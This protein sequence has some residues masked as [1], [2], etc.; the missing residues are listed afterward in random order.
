MHTKNICFKRANS[1]QSP[2]LIPTYRYETFRVLGNHGSDHLPCSVLLNRQN[3]TRATRPRAAFK[4][5]HVQPSQATVVDKLRCK[6]HKKGKKSA[7]QQPPWWTEDLDEAWRIK[8]KVAKCWQNL[9][10]SN[11]NTEEIDRAAEIMKTSLQNF[12]ELAKK[13]K[14]EKWESFCHEVNGDKALTKFWKLHRCK[15]RKHHTTLNKVIKLDTGERLVTDEE[16]GHVF[17]DRYLEQTDQKNLEDRMQLK[18]EIQEA[19]TE[20]LRY[21]DIPSFTTCSIRCILK[22]SSSTAPGP[23]GVSYNKI[24]SLSDQELQELADMYTN[25][26]VTGNIPEDWL[27]SYLAVI[28]KPGRDHSQ[29]NGYRI[30]TMQN[31]VGKLMEKQVA[32]QLTQD[33]EQKEALPEGLGSYRKGMDTWANAAVFAYDTYEGFQRKEETIAV[34]ID[35]EDAYNR[36]S[37]EVLIRM[38]GSCDINPIVVNWIAAA[39][40]R[41]T[42]ALRH[43]NW[44]SDPA[45]ITPGLPQ[46][47]PLSPVLYNVYTARLAMM[48]NP[49]GRILTFADDVLIYVKGR[50]R[51][52][53]SNNTQEVLS[54]VNGWCVDTGA[55]INP[56]KGTTLWC[57]LDNHIVKKVLPH[58]NM[59]G[60]TIERVAVMKYLG[61][62]F[63]RT[64]SFKDQVDNSV[65]KCTRG[66]TAVKVMAAAGIRQC[67]LFILFKAL[68]LSVIDYGLGLT[69]FS[70]AQIE[71]LER[72]QN[73][74]M[75]IVLGCPRNTSVTAMRY[76]LDLP[77][78]AERHKISQV[79]AM[80]TV[81]RNTTHLLH[82]ELGTAKGSRIKR[83]RS[84]LAEAED[85][86]TTVCDVKYIRKGEEWKKCDDKDKKYTKV[87]I[88]MGREKREQ[89]PTIVNSEIL[90]LIEQHTKKDD[91][92]IYTDGSVTRGERCGWGFTAKKDGKTIKEGSQ[93]YHCTTSS[94]KMEEEAASAALEWLSDTFH[95]GAAIVTDSQS[96]LKKIEQNMLKPEWKKCIEQ[97][98]LQSL[99]WIFTPGHAGVAGNE[100]ADR[101]AGTAAIGEGLLMGEKEVVSALREKVPEEM[102]DTIT[103]LQDLGVTRGKA[104][105]D[106]TSGWNRMYRNQTMTGTVGRRNL[107]YVLKR[108]TEQIWTCPD[109]NDG[110]SANNEQ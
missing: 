44:T 81:A 82:G 73:E 23:D 89:A 85:T 22:N 84:W 72:I 62:A 75:R 106:E 1:P 33:L 41:R 6:Q 87:V 103:R 55:V 99:V 91:V 100:R 58:V 14:I 95:D 7:L 109:C 61:I 54:R 93:A 63:D 101:L 69:T 94:M 77:S 28:P 40:M 36:V 108:M 68:V 18:M 66:L 24:E 60:K 39:L 52:E 11:A 34:A 107:S 104:A 46:G 76:M 5:R 26:L 102:N 30:I 13:S 16:R 86:T 71:R 8:R 74:G 59:G 51:E 105:K 47:S 17:L 19:A 48:E 37:Y 45:A 15:Q 110:T 80:F 31:T 98:H 50:D 78:I 49:N 65:A 25:S 79:K 12:K 38:L 53:M 64:L 83:G 70:R 29:L 56:L 20:D 21:T 35:L 67:V 10:R 90:E 97:S 3:A 43:G 88:T 92:I 96:M 42:V 2:N 27:H 4:Y 57:S 32:K 9:R